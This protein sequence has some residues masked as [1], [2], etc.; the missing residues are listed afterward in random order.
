[1]GSNHEKNWRSKSRDTLPLKGMN[2]VEDRSPY[3]LR[4]RVV[5]ELIQYSRTKDGLP[6]L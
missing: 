6:L 1:M 4:G 5:V 2:Y 3:E